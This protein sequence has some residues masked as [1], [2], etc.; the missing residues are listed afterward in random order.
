MD[1]RGE[2]EVWGV[3]VQIP[4]LQGA[5]KEGVAPHP[6][7]HIGS[8]AELLLIPSHISRYGIDV[9]RAGVFGLCVKRIFGHLTGGL[10]S[11][12]QISRD[13]HPKHKVVRYGR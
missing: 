10:R 5:N 11:T 4:S 2:V 8:V 6:D 3:A 1:K 12:N 9:V 7:Q 13:E